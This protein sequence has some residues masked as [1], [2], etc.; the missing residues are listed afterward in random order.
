MRWLFSY[1]RNPVIRSILEI[2]TVAALPRND[3]KILAATSN[4]LPTGYSNS[5]VIGTN[6]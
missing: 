4:S 5:S 1:G 2:A 3:S 6:R